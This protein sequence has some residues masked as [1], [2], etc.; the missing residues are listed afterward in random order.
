MSE[1]AIGRQAAAIMEPY[2]QA[3]WIICRPETR[4]MTM[5]RIE[6]QLACQRVSAWQVVGRG[7]SFRCPNCGAYGLFAGLLTMQSRCPHCSLL[8]E[9]EEGF[10]LGA[11]VVNYIL[12]ALLAVEAPC[13]LLLA[14]VLSPAL[15]VGIVIG[16]CLLLPFLFYRPAKSLWLM[17]YYGLFPRHLP[18]NG[19]IPPGEGDPL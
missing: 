2:R 13:L 17:T 5:N 11:M 4:S 14:G 18:A 16:L 8:F 3:Q 9:R 7:L 6:P 1:A 12:S 15:A 10:F 19:G